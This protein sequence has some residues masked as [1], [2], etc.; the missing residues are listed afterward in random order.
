MSS[1]VPGGTRR[2]SS[3]APDARPGRGPGHPGRG[4]RP[5]PRAGPD[6]LPREALTGL[7]GPTNR[8]RAGRQR[9]HGRLRPAPADRRGRWLA[10]RVPGSTSTERRAVGRCIAEARCW[11]KAWGA[12]TPGRPMPTRA[13]TCRM[14]A[15]SSS[16]GPG[17]ASLGDD[18]HRALPQAGRRPSPPTGCP[19]RRGAPGGSASRRPS[20]RWAATA[21]PS[22][23]S[24][25]AT[26]LAWP[27]G[28][29]RAGRRDPRQGRLHAGSRPLRRR[30]R[31]DARGR[32]PRARPTTARA[33]SEE[34]PTGRGRWARGARSTSPPASA[35]RARTSSAAWAAILE[36]AA[37]VSGSLR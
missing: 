12:P 24:A 27:N 7:D 31:D 22:S 2:S 16:P 4:R 36:A 13:S 8:L 26:A 9:E 30:R 11:S 33:G 6:K 3:G 18:R 5:G 35:R 20:G 1:S 19:G 37:A 21:W 15:G 34:E 32:P 14:T 10:R 23:S 28:S 25:I 17:G 29:A